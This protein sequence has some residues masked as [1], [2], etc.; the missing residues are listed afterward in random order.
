MVTTTTDP[1][2][3]PT[4]A[5]STVSSMTFAPSADASVNQS[6]ATTNYGTTQTVQ[7]DNSPILNGLL[8]FTVTGT[9]GYTV[10]SAKI[11][12]YVTNP[13]N[14]GGSFYRTAETSWSETGVTWNTAPAADASAFATVGAVTTGQWVEV[15]AST[16][17]IGR[18]H[19]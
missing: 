19:V 11:R 17:K 13:S 7:T 5:P 4:P 16:I 15:N 10:Q 3:T 1:T 9:T 18:A 2:P 6:T 12:L 8:K 14:V